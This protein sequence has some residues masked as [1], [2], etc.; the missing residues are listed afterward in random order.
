MQELIELDRR[1]QFKVMVKTYP[2]EQVNEVLKMVEERRI[3]GR[4]VLK[5]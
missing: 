3:P 2:L 1:K 4:A 5:P